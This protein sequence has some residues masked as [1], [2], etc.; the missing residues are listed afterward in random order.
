MRK[1]VRYSHDAACSLLLAV[2]A[3][4]AFCLPARQLKA[5][6]RERPSGARIG[7]DSTSGDSSA[8]R[9]SRSGG[10]KD[11]WLSGGIGAGGENGSGIAAILSAWYADGSVVIGA[12]TSEGAPWERETDTHDKAALIGLRARSTHAFVLGALGAGR[13]G[14]S[15]SNGEQSGSRTYFAGETSIA[16]GVEGGVTYHVIGIGIDAFSAR[17]R[18]FSYSAITLSLQLGYL[19]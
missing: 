2:I 17:T 19:E 16:F 7:A 6:T 12:R 18:R 8:S 10:R 15:H 4:T 3:A 1:P 13:T 11:L 14:G 9:S 5:Q